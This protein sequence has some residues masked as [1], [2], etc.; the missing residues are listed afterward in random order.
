MHLIVLFF[1]FLPLH[2]KVTNKLLDKLRDREVISEKK[3][4]NILAIRLVKELAP[5]EMPLRLEIAV[6][7]PK[8]NPFLIGTDQWFSNVLVFITLYAP[9]QSLRVLCHSMGQLRV[10]QH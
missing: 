5:L 8:C 6:V 7:I 4:E 10:A 2:Q 9:R 1:I 3:T